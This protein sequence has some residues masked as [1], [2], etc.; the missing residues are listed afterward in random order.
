[1]L[2]IDECIRDLIAPGGSVHEIQPMARERGVASLRDDAITKVLDG[3]TSYLEL[4]R[5]TV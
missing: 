2:V 1:V 4:L 3:A 5:A